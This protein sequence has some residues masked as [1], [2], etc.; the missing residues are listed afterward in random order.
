MLS[1][2]AI[3]DNKS[4]TY[5]EKISG[6]DLYEDNRI[7]LETYESKLGESGGACTSATYRVHFDFTN[8]T[9]VD[10]VCNIRLSSETLLPYQFVL[11]FTRWNIIVTDTT[12]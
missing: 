7:A 4:Y 12:S 2:G 8:T 10:I 9:Y 6:S 5:V 3:I 1:T 11:T